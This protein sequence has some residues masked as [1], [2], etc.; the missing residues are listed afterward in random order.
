MRILTE[1]ESYL[2]L[3]SRLAE[4]VQVF[5]CPFATNDQMDSIAVSDPF[6]LDV[7]SVGDISSIEQAPLAHYSTFV[8]REVSHTPTLVNKMN[9]NPRMTLVKLF[10]IDTSFAVHETIFKGPDKAA[11]E[12]DIKLGED[13]SILRLKRHNPFTKDRDID[14][15]NFV[16]D[17]W[18]ES[19]V[20]PHAETQFSQ[21]MP[22]TTHTD[23]E[24]TLN[25]T[26]VYQ[27]AVRNLE[28][29]NLNDLE[30]PPIALETIM[31]DLEGGIVESLSNGQ[32]SETL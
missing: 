16:V 4:L 6:L 8:F 17:D 9:Y 24:W 22:R 27:L 14:D 25:W 11:S 23:F 5:P 12:L 26:P 1:P 31:G 2:V 29:A 28:A 3:Y 20:A 19:V 15:E 21:A 13:N 7:P 10:W 32:T 30:R 18:D